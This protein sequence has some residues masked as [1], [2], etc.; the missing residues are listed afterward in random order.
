[1][2]K[3]KEMDIRDAELIVD[4]EVEIKSEPVDDENDVQFVTDVV[5]EQTRPATKKIRQEKNIKIIQIGTESNKLKYFLLKIY[6]NIKINK[7][8]ER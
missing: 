1:M 3:G 7:F 5:I 8:F 4:E 6:F 2:E